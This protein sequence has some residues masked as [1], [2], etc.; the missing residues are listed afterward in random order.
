MPPD[1]EL[2]GWIANLRERLQRGEVDGL[3]IRDAGGN[4]RDAS[5]ISRTFLAELDRLGSLPREQ[6]WEPSAD[7]AR[8]ALLDEFR[9][10]REQIG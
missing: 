6:R 7:D 5:Q 9:R 1:V 8:H 3:T 10:L 2:V 4:T